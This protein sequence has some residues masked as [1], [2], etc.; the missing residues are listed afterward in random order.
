[1]SFIGILFFII[2]GNVMLFRVQNTIAETKERY[3]VLSKI[4]IHQNEMKEVIANQLKIIF[5]VPFVLGLITGI[6]FMWFLSANIPFRSELI[7]DTLLISCIF[8]LFQFVYYLIS[9]KKVIHEVLS[10]YDSKA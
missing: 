7:R 8:F 1:M 5:F 9:K 6:L 2:M 4:G 3:A 10:E